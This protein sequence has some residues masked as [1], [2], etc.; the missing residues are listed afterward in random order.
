M[1]RRS[2]FARDERGVSSVLGAILV[3][4]IL[5]SALL[6]VNAFRAPEKGADGERAVARALETGMDALAAATTRGSSGPATVALELAPAAPSPSLLRGIVLDPLRP[7]TTFA[8][9]PDAFAMRVRHVT[10]AGATV[11]DLGSAASP[12]DLGRFAATTAGR[13]VAPQSVIVE[14][15]AA[16]RASAGGAVLAA[17]PDW[18]WTSS[19]G[20]RTL[21][22]TVPDLEGA[23]TNVT[24]SS[25]RI[26]TLAPQGTRAVGGDAVASSR[27]V[28]EVWSEHNR[29]WAAFLNETFAPATAVVQAGNA[30]ITLSSASATYAMRLEYV[31]WNVDFS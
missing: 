21:A 27:I 25:N 13:Y 9:E 24:D 6:Y 15:G 23:A 1:T 19:G 28:L 8:L 18:S 11:W 14:G 12:A 22:L 20:V 17:R 30:T 5:A 7:E 3:F 29:A 26:V 10:P 16:V 2:R 4:A 31:R